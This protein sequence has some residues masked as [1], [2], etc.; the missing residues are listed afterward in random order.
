[1]G[2][3]TAGDEFTYID[4]YL[5]SKSP[6]NIGT[7]DK[8]I[9]N[10]LPGIRD[11]EGM[12][13]MQV[14]IPFSYFVID[15]TNNVLRVTLNLTSPSV[16]DVYL[17]PGTYTAPQF[18]TMFNQ[19]AGT[20]YDYQ[21][22]YL[23]GCD[24]I[25]GSDFVIYIP[26]DGYGIQAYTYETTQQITFYYRRGPDLES[27]A[28]DALDFSIDF[29][30]ARS[31]NQVMGFETKLY[32]SNSFSSPNEIYITPT[33]LYS[34]CYIEAPYTVEMAG[35]SYIYIQSDLAG[36]VQDGACRTEQS[37]EQ[38][39][40]AAQVNNN[41][42]GMINFQV[43]GQPE[44]LFFSK[45]SLT[46]AEFSLRL[47]NRTSYCSG[48]DSS[49]YNADGTP[50]VQN[51]LQLLG[52]GYQIHIRFYKRMDTI[53]DTVMDNQT[54]DKYITS[55]AVHNSQGRPSEVHFKGKQITKQMGGVRTVGNNYDRV[56]T[57]P[58]KPPDTPNQ[59]KRSRK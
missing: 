26:P 31:A 27:P 15:A 30:V 38:I 7:R 6:S 1:M 49:Y 13:V 22:P 42:T 24:N 16:I 56:S 46:K 43:L 41:Y 47:G 3:A 2:A 35:P 25:S 52:Q 34:T 54:G 32:T 10:F 33:L 20:N 45:T 29:R 23:G 4:C 53:G 51:Y 9:F 17:I 5:D 18:I 40:M 37:K 39:L 12:C 50:K 55:T 8:P 11:V 48:V 21:T 58:Q 36:Q 57:Y 44:K 19:V 59:F 14:T 28:V